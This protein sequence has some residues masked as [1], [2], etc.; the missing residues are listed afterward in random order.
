MCVLCLLVVLVLANA[1]FASGEENKNTGTN[2]VNNIN[3]VEDLEKVASSGALKKD[4][5]SIL[6]KLKEFAQ[7]GGLSREKLE[8]FFDKGLINEAQRKELID[9]MGLYQYL[10]NKA[11]DYSDKGRDYLKSQLGW[12]RVG[13]RG[14]KWPMLSWQYWWESGKP[15]E[16]LLFGFLLSLS[17]VLFYPFSAQVYAE[18]IDN[19]RTKGEKVYFMDMF[20]PEIDKMSAYEYYKKE[21]NNAFSAY[22]S[23]LIY[24][25]FPFFD[26]FIDAEKSVPHTFIVI[27]IFLAITF[28]YPVLMGIPILNTFLKIITL[29]IIGLHFIWRALI[30]SV[31][32]S[33]FPVFL[34]NWVERE[35]KRKVYKEKLLEQYIVEKAKIEVS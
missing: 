28:G 8:S 20:N 1:G 23:A 31:V 3:N 4:D 14:T 21:K 6:N 16:Y 33:F 25:L 35:K 10:K 13:E 22:K 17:L 30:I 29:E 11:L 9:E 12:V 26:N 18:N 24:Y 15:K 7:K 19:E 2:Q 32:I 34:A 27:C 5:P